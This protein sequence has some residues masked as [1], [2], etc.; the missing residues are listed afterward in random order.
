MT[1]MEEM[2]LCVVFKT[3]G[4]TGITAVPDRFGLLSGEDSM[5]EFESVEMTVRI[6]AYSRS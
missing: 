1:T 4:T 6:A 3:D 5:E 2:I